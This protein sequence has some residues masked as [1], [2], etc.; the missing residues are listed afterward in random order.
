MKSLFDRG[1]MVVQYLVL[2]PHSK[3]VRGL[4]LVAHWGFFVCMV[5][6]CMV[7]MDF[8]WFPPTAQKNIQILS[9]GN[10]KLP[11]SVNVSENDGLSLC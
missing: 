8:L 4:N 10:S 2:L 7:Y 11:I 9:A 6:L 1:A 5:S 3:K